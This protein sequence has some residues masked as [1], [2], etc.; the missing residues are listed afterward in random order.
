MNKNMKTHKPFHEFVC[1]ICGNRFWSCDYIEHFNRFT[2]EMD[3]EE[4]CLLCGCVVRKEG[5]SCPE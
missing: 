4:D 2:N 3:L 1:R 5:G